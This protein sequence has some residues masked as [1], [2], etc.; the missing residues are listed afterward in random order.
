MARQ[1]CAKDI[2]ND[3]DVKDVKISEENAWESISSMIN[4]QSFLE[5]NSFTRKEISYY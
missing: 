3:K 1:L 4:K 2:L 5:L